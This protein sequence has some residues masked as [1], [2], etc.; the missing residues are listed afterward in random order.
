MGTLV[1][2]RRGAPL[3]VAFGASAVPSVLWP[4]LMTK[5][6]LYKLNPVEPQL[7]KAPGF[8]RRT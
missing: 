4:P 8:S 6:G 1:P 3:E 2:L 5:A 7:E